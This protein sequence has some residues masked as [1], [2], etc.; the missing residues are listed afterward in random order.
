VPSQAWRPTEFDKFKNLLDAT[1]DPREDKDDLR[2]SRIMRV[3]LLQW[4]LIGR[5][6]D[7]M[8]IKLIRFPPT[9][10]TLEMATPKLSGPKK[11]LKKEMLQS[12]FFLHQITRSCVLCLPLVFTWILWG[13]LMIN[14]SLMQIL[15]L[16][17]QRVAIIL[18]AR[19]WT[20][21]FSQT[22]PNAND[23]NFDTHII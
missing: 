10:V 20:R 21:L 5:I 12:K 2:C 18:L 13:A 3:L 19:C 23:G 14:T 4:H 6:D 15:S 16:V 8:D 17:I 9:R 11:L 1:G 22:Y 7:M